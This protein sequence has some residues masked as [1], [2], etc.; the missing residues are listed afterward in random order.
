[1][2]LVRNA[3]KELM[4]LL[5]EL[6]ATNLQATQAHEGTDNLVRTPCRLAYLKA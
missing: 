1:M 2:A 6:S 4:V 5:K 3:Q